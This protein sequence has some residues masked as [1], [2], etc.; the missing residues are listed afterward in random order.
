[1]PLYDDVHAATWLSTLE[2]DLL[3]E[4]NDGLRAHLD[5]V[6]GQCDLLERIV[7]KALSDGAARAFSSALPAQKD[8]C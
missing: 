7:T 1:M 8:R 3:R 6:Q 4:E 5:V 2:T